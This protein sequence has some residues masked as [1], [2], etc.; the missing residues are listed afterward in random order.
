M[1]GH[2]DN[3]IVIDAPI[4]VVWRVAN[5]VRQWPELFAGEYAK[6]EVLEEEAD[7][8][9]FRLTTEPTPEGQSYS[10]VSERHMDR[11]RGCVS[12][13]RIELG[14]F[15]Y[16]HIFQSFTPVDGGVELRWVQDFEV[17]PGAPLTDEQFKARIDEGSQEN[18]RNHKAVIEARARAAVAGERS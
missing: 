11:E 4:D 18:L 13:R 1:S 6:A 8:V 10:W 2:T 12:S 3:R 9:R 17:R 14:P 5:D 7:R 15:R 16:M